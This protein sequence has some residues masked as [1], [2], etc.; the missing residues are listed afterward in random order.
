MDIVVFGAGSLGSLVG[1]LLA[2]E[3]EVTLVGRDPHV[4]TVR[5]DGL[6]VEGACEASLR[7]AATTDGTGLA[8]DVALVSVKAF[9]T[10]AAAAALA[11]G[12]YGAVCSLQNGLGNEE[13][14]AAALDAPVLAGTATYGAKLGEPGVV[15]C[16]GVGELVVG[17]LPGVTGGDGE[18]WAERLVDACR[19]AGLAATVDADMARRRWAKLAINAGINPVTALVR[20]ENGVVLEDPASELATAATREAVAVARAEG[21][22][23]AAGATVERMREVATATAAN[24]SS[25]LQDV[26]AGRRTEIDAILGA[27]LERAA[28]AGTEVPTTR[29]LYGLVAAWEAERGLR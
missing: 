24:R 7:P 17:P 27:V 14:L 12:T 29:V 18:A 23:L 15:E 13:T 21:I 3:H 26:D 28:A 5:E 25:M 10:E 11:T 19:S 8:A 4:A 16:T 20:A 2:R 9:D 1:G 22:E 6:V